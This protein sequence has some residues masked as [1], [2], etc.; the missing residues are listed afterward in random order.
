MIKK[1]KERATIALFLF[2]II[3]GMVGPFFYTP[4]Q[5]IMVPMIFTADYLL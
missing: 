2:L 1:F 5:Q 4:K 3:G